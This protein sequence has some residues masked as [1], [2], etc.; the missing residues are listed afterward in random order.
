V[1][2]LILVVLLGCPAA[3]VAQ[4][5][6]DLVVHVPT[7]AENAHEE[8]KTIGTDDCTLKPADRCVDGPGMRKL[9]RFSVLALNRGTADLFLGAPSA[10]DPLFVFSECH[11]HFHFE[12]FA[13]YELRPR[14]G[15]TAIKS[16]QKRSFCIEDLR[17]DPDGPVA[18]TCTGDADCQG[19][20]VCAN[21]V[22][23]YN[24]TYQGIQVGRGD[25]YE[26]NLDCQ[27]ID[28]TDVPPGEYDL[29]VMLNT[30]QILPESDYDNDAAMIPVTVGPAAD[31]PVP[32]VKVRVKKKT[33]VGKPLK[34]GWKTKLEGGRKNIEGY[35]VWLAR[36]GATFSELLA[37]GVVERKLRWTVSG[38]ASDQAVV[39]VVA[40]TNALQRGSGTSRTLRIVP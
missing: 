17:A 18:R 31:A 2:A 7:L 24:C 29:W 22:C 30:K 21:G 37:T 16:G 40:W 10:N 9:L 19:H 15:I 38:A 35:D 5:L 11:N 3:V 4:D 27:W 34:I 25:I 13:S 14:G 8:L 1:R 36:D 32:V 28:T 12:S 20:G 39:K 33:K 23:Q 26:S 6:P